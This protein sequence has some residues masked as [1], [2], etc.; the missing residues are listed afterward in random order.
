VFER[1]VLNYLGGVDP[2]HKFP[3]RGLTSSEQTTW[4]YRGPF[5][6]FGFLQDLDFIDEITKA[7][8]NKERLRLVPS[9]LNFPGVDS[10]LYNPDEVLT[11]IQIIR[12]EHHILVSR[13]RR[14]QSW[15][16]RDTRLAGLRPSKE[17]PWRF[18]FVAPS[19]E[20]SFELQP[21]EGDTAQGE[22]TGMV[23]Q[24]IN[25]NKEVYVRVMPTISSFP[26]S[27]LH[28]GAPSPLFFYTLSLPL[29]P[30]LHRRHRATR[31]R[32]H[33]TT[34]A[35][36]NHNHD[37]CS[38]TKCQ[39]AFRARQSV[40]PIDKAES[41]FAIVAASANVLEPT[42]ALNAAFVA[43]AHGDWDTAG[44]VFCGLVEEDD[45]NYA[46]CSTIQSFVMLGWRVC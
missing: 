36:T 34:R 19:D 37:Q 15:L 5:R 35:V 42:K 21:L 16:K 18:I 41:H 1:Q 43:S 39:A 28:P 3:I 29:T 6:R 46:V 11:C 20:A 30:G 4:T 40:S 26:V 27:D 25:Y 31:A 7:V 22:W 33:P 44:E 2:E 17:R 12:R 45:A 13:L 23:H 14:I 24:Y 8:Q 32:C 10:I 9:A 38:S